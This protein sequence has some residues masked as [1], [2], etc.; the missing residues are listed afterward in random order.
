MNNRNGFFK[1]RLLAF[2]YAF[3]GAWYLFKNEPPVKVQFITAL[4]VCAAGF[5]FD[6]TRT[7]WMLQLLSIGLVLSIEGCNTAIEKIADFIHPE[8]HVKIGVIKDVAAGAV[9]IAATAAFIVGLIIYVPY[10][11]ALF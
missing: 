11:I 4:V 8:Y 1:G 10:F 9:F 5:Y 6:I 3:Q 2:K 7:E